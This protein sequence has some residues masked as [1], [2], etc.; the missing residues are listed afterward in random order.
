MNS[1]SVVAMLFPDGAADITAVSLPVHYLREDAV[2]FQDISPD[3][4]EALEGGQTVTVEATVR[5]RLSSAEQGRV[6]L[7]VRHGDGHLLVDPPFEFVSEGLGTVDFAVTLTVPNDTNLITV[8]ALLVSGSDEETLT[9]P[10]VE[11]SIERIRIDAVDPPTGLSLQ[12]GEEVT[13]DLDVSYNLVSETNRGLIRVDVEDESGAVL[14]PIPELSNYEW[15]V[16]RGSGTID[17]I[18]RVVIPESAT[19]IRVIA[20]LYDAGSGGEILLADDEKTFSV[21][22]KGKVVILGSSPEIPLELVRVTAEGAQGESMSDLSN[23]QGIY[24]LPLGP[25]VYTFEAEPPADAEGIR[26]PAGLAAAVADDDPELPK[27]EMGVVNRRQAVINLAAQLRNLGVYDVDRAAGFN[28]PFVDKLGSGPFADEVDDVTA[29]AQTFPVE[30]TPTDE[31]LYRLSLAIG[32]AQSIADD[33][34]EMSDKLEA[35][36]IDLLADLVSLGQLNEK[37]SKG[38]KGQVA[39]T[40]DSIPVR[41]STVRGDAYEELVTAAQSSNGKYTNNLRR[42]VG[43]NLLAGAGDAATLEFLNTLFISGAVDQRPSDFIKAVGER[44]DILRLLL[45]AHFAW[46]TQGSLRQAIETAEFFSPYNDQLPDEANTIQAAINLSGNLTQQKLASVEGFLDSTLSVGGSIKNKSGY[47]ATSLSAASAVAAPEAAA[48]LLVAGATM[49]EFAALLA[50][51]EKGVKGVRFFELLGRYVGLMR[52]W[53][54][55]LPRAFQLSSFPQNRYG[56]GLRMNGRRAAG[57][58]PSIARQTHQEAS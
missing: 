26:E 14:P 17:P 57:V 19:E 54:M 36:L 13:F 12:K 47:I 44:S 8:D 27:I 16:S 40:D 1:V 37:L 4:Q 33:A 48:V 11:Y 41:G 52:E 21:S 49:A 31:R 20:S 58:H 56:D 30:P 2:E 7:Q 34:S 46:Q 50:L 39:K 24:E 38:I 6:E 18:T 43:D 45:E 25:G 22:R 51:L 53:E 3:P 55:I 5:Y 29:F 23:S 42:H 10:S 9:D 32:A 28:V 15:E 35:V